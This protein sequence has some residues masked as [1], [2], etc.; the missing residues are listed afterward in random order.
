MFDPPPECVECSGE[1]EKV[2]SVPA[3]KMREYLP[4]VE[5]EDGKI[6]GVRD[7][8]K[9]NDYFESQQDARDKKLNKITK[10]MRKRYGLDP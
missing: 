5:Q 10:T 4:L 8:A 7:R 3:V 1:T 9:R 6:R 2:L